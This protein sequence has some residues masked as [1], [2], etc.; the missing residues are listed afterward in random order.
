MGFEYDPHN[1]LRH[2]SYWFEQDEKAEW[3]LSKNA[4]EE[5]PAG[6]LFD[7]SAVPDRFYYDVETTGSLSPSEVCLRVS[8]YDVGLA[9]T[10][11]TI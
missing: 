9:Q 10:H 4:A 1:K 7:F 3:P 2:T 8:S 5:A 11:L 6:E